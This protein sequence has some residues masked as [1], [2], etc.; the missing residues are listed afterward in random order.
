MNADQLI[1]Y[2]S[3]AVYIII[4]VVTAARA[5][6]RP[7]RANVD[8]ALFFASIALVIGLVVLR[9]LGLLPQ[10]QLFIVLTVVFLLLIGYM[11][12]RLMDDFTH[13]P[14][15]IM[16]SAEVVLALLALATALVPPTPSA[17]TLPT[18]LTIAVLMYP[19]VLL[20][21]TTAGSYAPHTR[22]AG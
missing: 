2:L 16:R 17:A 5:V 9:Q 11:L 4:F 10:G 18:W 15:R 21:Y 7:L 1:Q 6:R 19:V 12:L 3:W 20:L 22:Q 8:I 13:V 14:R